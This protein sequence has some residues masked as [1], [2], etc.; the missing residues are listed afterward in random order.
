MPSPDTVGRGDPD[1]GPDGGPDAGPEIVDDEGADDPDDPGDVAA[2]CFPEEHPA[3]ASAATT[4]VAVRQLNVKRR[5]GAGPD[6]RFVV[7]GSP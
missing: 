3:S 2:L 7:T 6:V 1:V 4:T 5:R